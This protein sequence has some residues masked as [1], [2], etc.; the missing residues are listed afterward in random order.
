MFIFSTVNSFL[1]PSLQQHIDI[2]LPL[3]VGILVKINIPAGVQGYLPCLCPTALLHGP[4]CFPLAQPRP[5]SRRN[6]SKALLDTR[7]QAVWWAHSLNS[8]PLP[9]SGP[10]GAALRP[11]PAGETDRALCAEAEW[12]NMSP[13]RVYSHFNSFIQEAERPCW[14]RRLECHGGSCLD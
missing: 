10:V 2:Q 11:G 7:A 8:C 3:W 12:T 9:L 14:L 13:L 6:K 1:S 4:Y 5:P